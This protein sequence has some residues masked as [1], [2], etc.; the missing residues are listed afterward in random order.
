MN[1][2]VNNTNSIDSITYEYL[3]STSGIDNLIISPALKAIQWIELVAP[4]LVTTTLFQVKI[5]LERCGRFFSII[6]IPAS[7]TDFQESVADSKNSKTL[8]KFFERF[9]Y[10]FKKFLSLI[11][12]VG[13]NLKFA[14]QES[15]IFLSATQIVII[16]RC[17]LIESITSFIKKIIRIKKRITHI[18]YRSEPDIKFA[19][20]ILVKK[21]LK[22]VSKTLGFGVLLFGGGFSSQVVLLSLSTTSLVFSNFKYYYKNIYNYD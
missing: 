22:L 15:F 12:T 4:P 8:T 17:S 9:I 21:I 18:I 3:Q 2:I 6:T 20:F 1:E 11:N 19:L 16:N 14:Y 13:S 5:N 10:F 7:I